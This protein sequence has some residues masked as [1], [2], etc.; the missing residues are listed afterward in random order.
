MSYSD[1]SLRTPSIEAANRA[2]VTALLIRS[3]Y[4]VYRSEADIDGE[5]LVVR[6]PGGELIA[7]QL[8]GRPLVDW[9]RYGDRGIWMLFPSQKYEAG[10]AR[11]WYLVPHDQFFAWV[12][13]RH[14]HAPK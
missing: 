2:E 6:T 14:G 3:G 8:K 1:V 13:N 9:K 4:R 7:V 12:K 10:K 11:D 5:D